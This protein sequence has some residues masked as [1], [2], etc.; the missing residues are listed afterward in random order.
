MGKARHQILRGAWARPLLRL[1]G[2]LAGVGCMAGVTACYGAPYVP[3]PHDP[4]VTID[5]FTYTPASPIHVGDTLTLTATLNHPTNAGWLQATVKKPSLAQG[6]LYDNGIAPDSAPGDG[7]FTGTLEWSPPLDDGVGLP[8][9]VELLWDDG[10]PGLQLGGPPLT[11]LPPEVG[12][13]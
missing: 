1:A 13:P 7:I 8:V 6:V 12:Q 3:L 11:I 4:T 2:W 9:W 10:Y 5:H